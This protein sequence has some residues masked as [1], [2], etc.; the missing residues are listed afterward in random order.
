MRQLIEDP[1]R[2]IQCPKSPDGCVAEFEDDDFLSGGRDALYYVRAIQEATPAINAGA[3]RCK[4]D[5]SGACVEVHPCYG[6]YRTS[7]DDDC[8]SPAEER[9]WSSPLYLHPAG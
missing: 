5:E 6:D 2:V 3:L 1:W 4:R 7:K 9:A 8:L